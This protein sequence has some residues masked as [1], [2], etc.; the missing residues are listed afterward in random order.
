MMNGKKMKRQMVADYIVY[1][2]VGSYFAKTICP[3]KIRE[4]RMFMYYKDTKEDIQYELEE[5][6]INF[7]EKKMMKNLPQEIWNERVM[8]TLKSNVAVPGKTDIIFSG[9]GWE[10]KISNDY[11]FS[12]NVKISYDLIEDVG[13]ITEK[14]G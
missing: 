14:A 7:V 13:Y 10:L 3:S 1:M 12:T 4:K 9:N 2:M 6:C 11:L 8:V 5:K